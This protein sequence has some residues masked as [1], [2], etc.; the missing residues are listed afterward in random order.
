MKDRSTM[1]T[2]EYYAENIFWGLITM[3]WYKKTIFRCLPNVTYATS[4]I[5]LWLMLFVSVSVCS[6]CFFRKKRTG[7]NVCISLLI[8]YGL[9]TVGSYWRTLQNRIVIVLLVSTVLSLL[10]GILVM[11]RRMNKKK[12]AK[13]VIAKK[14][15]KWITMTG[16]IY[17][18]AMAV[19]MMPLLLQGTF[20]MTLFKPRVKAEIGTETE[21]QTIS[22]NI[23]TVLK[24]QEEEWAS[25]TTKDK[26]NVLQ[27]VANI[28][29]NYLGI[30]NELNV[31]ASN[32]PEYTLACYSD[33]SHTI[34]INLEHLESNSAA[35]VLNSCCH[36]AYHSYQHR[37]VDAYIESPEEIQ[38]LHIYR[39]VSTYADELAA[40]VDGDED[41]FSY[42]SQQCEKDAREYAEN[43]VDDYYSRINEYLEG[44]DD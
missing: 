27:C 1:R 7:W 22:K 20:G 37:L 42:Y 8:S 9:Y 3:I 12:S 33:V 6:G 28:E 18:V 5:I 31:G 15:R 32:L 38:K 39:N 19:I 4:R 41:F 21:K 24:L 10:I 2:I 40:Y 11:T 23:D 30:S 13:R 14:L 36:E 35:E 44:I 26:L 43:A 17:A 34:Y 16:N 29:A 25:L